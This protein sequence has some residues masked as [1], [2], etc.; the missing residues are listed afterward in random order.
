M[1]YYKIL[2][3]S[4]IKIKAEKQNTKFGL[5]CR[6]T[7]LIAIKLIFLRIVISKIMVR[8]FSKV[9]TVSKIVKILFYILFLY[10][11]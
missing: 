5:K 3:Q 6:D 10:C 2:Y 9:K 8:A 11:T 1:K 7:L 4:K